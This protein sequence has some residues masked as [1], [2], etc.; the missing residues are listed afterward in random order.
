MGCHSGKGGHRLADCALGMAFI[1]PSSALASL[2]F[3]SSAKSSAAS[4][5]FPSRCRCPPIRRLARPKASLMPCSTR[6]W[7]RAAPLRACALHHSSCVTLRLSFNLP[8]RIASHPR[9]NRHLH[10][11]RTK[12]ATVAGDVVQQRAPTSTGRTRSTDARRSASVTSRRASF[13]LRSPVKWRAG[14]SSRNQISQKPGTASHPC[15]W[16]LSLVSHLR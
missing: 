14:W 9:V 12:P 3:T 6:G 8:Q 7:T 16:R 10:R 15:K 4:A 1:S 13:L 11:E 2:R 5:G